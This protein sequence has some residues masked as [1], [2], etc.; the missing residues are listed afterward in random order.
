M[1]PEVTIV[2]GDTYVVY[3]TPSRYT[4]IDEYG[5]YGNNGVF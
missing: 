2:G 4:I 1:D 3:Y 5:E